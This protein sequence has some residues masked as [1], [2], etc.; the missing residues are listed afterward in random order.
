MEEANVVTGEAAAAPRADPVLDGRTGPPAAPMRSAID[1]LV[2]GRPLGETEVG[3][4]WCLKALHPAETTVISS[5]MPTRETRSFATVAFQQLNLLEMPAAYDP[6]K[7]YDLTIYFHRDPTLLFSY[8]F[9]QVGAAD[10]T[11][12]VHSTQMANGTH[13]QEHMAYR[14]NCERFRLTSSSISAYFDG[15]S[16]TDQGHLVC[17]QTDLPRLVVPLLVPGTDLP[18]NDYGARLPLCFYQDD[19]PLMPQILQATRPYQGA[20]NK[21]VYCPSKLQELGRWITTNQSFMMPGSSTSTTGSTGGTY[22]FSE[23]GGGSYFADQPYSDFYG[24]FPY[25]VPAG[26]G[27]VPRTFAQADSTLTSIFFTGVA[28]TSTV[29]VTCRW[30]IDMIVRPGTVY[31]PFVKMPP[32]ED[33]GALRMYAEISRRLQDGYPSSY[34]NLGFLLPLISKIAGT[35]GPMILPRISTFFSRRIAEKQAANKTSALSIFAN[36]LTPDE[37]AEAVALGQIPE[38]ERTPAQKARYDALQARSANPYGMMPVASSALS[39]LFKGLASKKFAAP[40]APQ[41]VVI[42]MKRRSSGG[43]RKKSKK[44]KKRRRVYYYDDE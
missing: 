2:G 22:P 26:G 18:V 11:G 23:L 42:Q 8:K 7:T 35:I 20:A 17:G 19:P 16:E 15:A 38:A 10:V 41:P 30:T 3:K 37:G 5:P 29:R 14:S 6:A 39:A 1:E 44:G 25:M 34:N 12:Y 24:T 36:A 33:L 32:V 31:A 21:G 28:S 13:Y 43:K 9:A 4:A 40:S 27:S